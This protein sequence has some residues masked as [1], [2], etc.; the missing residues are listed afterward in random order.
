MQMQMMVLFTMLP[1][2]VMNY[3]FAEQCQ[4]EPTKVASMVLFGNFFAIVTLPVLLVVAFS[5]P[6]S[7]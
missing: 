1:P 6:I 2:A 3:L 7:G 4:I 5:L